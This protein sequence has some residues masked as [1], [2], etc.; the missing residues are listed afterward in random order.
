MLT[1]ADSAKTSANAASFRE[2]LEVPSG[3]RAPPMPYPRGY[4][5]VMDTT[6][7]ILAIT[8]GVVG[9][10]LIAI[11]VAIVLLARHNR[12]F[13]RELRRLVDNNVALLEA[14]ATKQA[15]A[16]R[17]LME[18]LRQEAA[19][20]TMPVL[21]LLDEPPIGIRDQPWAAVRVRNVGNGSALNFVV[22]MRVAGHLYHSAGAEAKGF[23]QDLH[24]AVGDTFEPGPFQNMLFVG[25]AHGYLDPGFAV[26]GDDPSEN[27][28][29]YCG[30]A[31]GNRFRYNL[32][33]GDPADFW[34]RG[35]DAPSWAGAWD[36]RLSGGGVLQRE[37]ES[38]W[39]V[40]DHDM[41]RLVEALHD[42]LDALRDATPDQHVGLTGRASRRP[43]VTE[44]GSDTGTGS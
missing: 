20:A 36:P 1:I 12:A 43:R 25:D 4:T 32:R 2:L 17:G 15:D 14:A 39:A 31:V 29:A 38:V 37:A 9:L 11:A 40:P 42:V 7:I 26:V 34:E 6:T 44:P 10:T 5:R 24:L 8:A 23:S 18:Q 16:A 3:R 19:V 22:W 27:L 13:N 35:T 28:M 30:D 21:V 41:R 33:T